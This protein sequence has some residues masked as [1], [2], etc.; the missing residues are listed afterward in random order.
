MTVVALED[1]MTAVNSGPDENTEQT[2]GSKFLQNLFHSVT[3]S[4]FQSPAHHL[5][6][7][8]KKRKTSQQTQKVCY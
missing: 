2:V 4:G 5:H 7:V 1:W 8:Q 3:G 6:T